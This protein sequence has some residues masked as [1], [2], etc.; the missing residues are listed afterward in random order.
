MSARLFLVGALLLAPLQVA[1]QPVGETIAAIR[2][3]FEYGRFEESLAHAQVRI[4]QGELSVD[5]LIELHKLAGLSAFNLGKQADA[6]RHLIALIR[7]NPD[8]VLD[9]FAVPPP[10]VKFFDK[11]K[12]DNAQELELIRQARRAEQ[13][14]REAAA[15]EEARRKEEEQRRRLEELSRRVTLRTVERKSYLVNFLPFGLGQFQQERAGTGILIA[16]LQGGLLTTTLVS[17]FAYNSFAQRTTLRLTEYDDPDPDRAGPL[18]VEFDYIPRRYEAPARNWRTAHYASIWGF[19][20]V[21][22]LGVL[23]S[24]LRHRDEVVTT[25]VEEPAPAPAGATPPAQPAARPGSREL[26]TG[27]HPW[28]APLPGG[29]GAGVTVTF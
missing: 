22:A 26:Q 3:E 17:Y 12:L 6:E 4:D 8:Y 10:A 21:Y 19:V 5:Q 15:R 25:T 11:M 16:A 7:L 18:V 13:I 20:G 14:Q 28:F 1:A 24:A 9:P 23:D 29:A 27:V 2:A